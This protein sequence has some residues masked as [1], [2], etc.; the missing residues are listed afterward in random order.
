M[1]LKKKIIYLGAPIFIIV[2]LII[3]II[4]GRKKINFESF[5]SKTGINSIQDIEY[6]MFYINEG[7]AWK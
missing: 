7:G 4:M 3:T 2:G 6:I 1:T 5:N